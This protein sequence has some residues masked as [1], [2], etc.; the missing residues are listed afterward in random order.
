MLL[1]LG[2]ESSNSSGIP[3]HKSRMRKKEQGYQKQNCG[4]RAL[5]VRKS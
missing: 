5:G 2:E 4:V 1:L 3:N